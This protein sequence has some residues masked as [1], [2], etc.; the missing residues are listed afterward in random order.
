[1]KKKCITDPDAEIQIDDINHSKE[2]KDIHACLTKFCSFSITQM[3]KNQQR[4][5]GD[6]C[7]KVKEMLK[8]YTSSSSNRL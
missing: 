6:N 3:L 1:M 7:K 4:A 5:Y 8:K 2:N